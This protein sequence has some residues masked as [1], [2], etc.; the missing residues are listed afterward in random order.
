MYAIR[1]YYEMLNERGGIEAD[2]TLCRR[3]ESHYYIV[4]GTAFGGHD[5]GWIKRHL[6]TDRITSYNV[7][8]TKLLRDHATGDTAYYDAFQDGHAGHCPDDGACRGANA[9]PRRGAIAGAA[10]AGSEKKCKS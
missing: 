1:S 7:C 5:F 4:T 2:L 3:S 6:P 9:G 10:A 8:Y